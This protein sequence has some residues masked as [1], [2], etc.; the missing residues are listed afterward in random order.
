V[1]SGSKMTG[2]KL[3]L[4]W[5]RISPW[6][7]S[8]FGLG[9]P[10]WRVEVRVTSSID[11]VITSIAP[12]TQE[13]VG[14]ERSLRVVRRWPVRQYTLPCRERLRRYSLGSHVVARLR[15]GSNALAIFRNPSLSLF[16]L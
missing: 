3:L 8:R 15:Q 10:P 2:H 13:C 9:I 12:A 6:D 1:F 5:R 7:E 11:L 16:G 4:V 14:N